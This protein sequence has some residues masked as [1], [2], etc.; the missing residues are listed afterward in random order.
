M[1]SQPTYD[2]LATKYRELSAQLEANPLYRD[3]QALKHVLDM[4][5]REHAD[6]ATHSSWKEKPLLTTAE[7]REAM[8]NAAERHVVMMKN[9][10]ITMKKLAIEVQ[11]VGISIR[12]KYA[13]T[14]L[15]ATLSAKKEWKLVDKKRG[16]WQ[17]TD[18]AFA[19]ARA[20]HQFTSGRAPNDTANAFRPAA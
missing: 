2:E 15:G 16:L 12:G 7:E 17:M 9:S 19:A 3:L 8:V 14:T 18:E 20:R 1:L 6:T 10:A 5:E 11:N 13:G 4:Y